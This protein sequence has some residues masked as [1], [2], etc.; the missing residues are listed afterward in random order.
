MPTPE[1]R[2]RELRV[3]L[4][5]ATVTGAVAGTVRAVVS[6]LIDHAGSVL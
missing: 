1:N 3:R 6:W 4:L 2:T 5:L